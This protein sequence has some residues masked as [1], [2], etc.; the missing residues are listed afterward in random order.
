MRKEAENWLKQSKADLKTAEDCLRD[1]NYY[2]S[3]F[4][5]QQAVEKSLKGY[6]IIKRKEFPP[7]THNLLELAL[8]LSLPEEILKI[9]RELT[10]EFIIS[11]YPDAV[12]GVPAELYDKSKSE[13]LLKVTRRFFEW[14]E[15]ELKKL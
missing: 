5:C 11:R 1:E 13:R 4:F 15:E 10:P 14:M 6:Y 8:E 9:A 7:R 12:S 3:A 2:A